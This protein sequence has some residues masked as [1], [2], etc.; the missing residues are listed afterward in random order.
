MKT[1]IKASLLTTA[2]FAG[3]FAAQLAAAAAGA[4]GADLKPTT[5]DVAGPHRTPPDVPTPVKVFASNVQSQFTGQQ[6]ELKFVVDKEGH[7]YN[8]ESTDPAVDPNLVTEVEAS[9]QFWKFTPAIGPDGK[10]MERTVILPIIIG[11]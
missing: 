8:L 1:A 6:F 5:S 4:P 2:M 11:G 3:L 7:P 10:P 9:V